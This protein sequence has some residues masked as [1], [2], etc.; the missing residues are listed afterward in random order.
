MVFEREKQSIKRATVRFFDFVKSLVLRGAPV[1]K[2]ARIYTEE[3]KR[4]CLPELEA[5]LAELEA[6]PSPA[7]LA[8]PE[9]EPTPAPI[10]ATTTPSAEE[11]A[12]LAELEAMLGDDATT[13][14]GAKSWTKTADENVENPQ[15]KQASP[16]YGAAG[17]PVVVL[18][19]S[20][21]FPTKPI[22]TSSKSSLL[23]LIKASRSPLHHLF[24]SPDHP[25]KLSRFI[26]PTTWSRSS[27]DQKDAHAIRTAQKF[28]A[29]AFSLNLSAKRIK[30]VVAAD[31]PVELLAKYIRREMVKRLGQASPFAFQLEFNAA[32]RLH[33]HG[34]VCLSLATE[35]ELE[36]VKLALVQAG[37]KISGRAG[38]TQ[39][40]FK[41]LYDADGW[42]TYFS[43]TTADTQRRLSTNK[44]MHVSRQLNALAEQDWSARLVPAPARLAA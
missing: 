43:K 2:A 16:A 24:G 4:L 28:K 1:A 26:P 11:L 35:A 13:L 15:A 29:V 33:V 31:D 7:P 36:L 21:P 42:T 34:V 23:D 32:G 44:I 30:A 6:Q 3:E 18:H 17:C 19:P 20:N 41:E 27:Q 8:A 22:T 39:C 25:F 40:L 5:M 37:G 12:I 14:A 9:P 10:V 38:S